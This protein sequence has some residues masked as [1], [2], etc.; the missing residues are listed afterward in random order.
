MDIW[1]SNIPVAEF[2]K[3]INGLL[4]VSGSTRK[5]PT[6]TSYRRVDRSKAKTRTDSVAHEKKS[7][8][9]VVSGV[10]GGGGGSWKR[11][12]IIY[13]HRIEVVQTVELYETV[14]VLLSYD[15]KYFFVER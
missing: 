1:W 6:S 13:T 11:R 7:T 3:C 5:T 10:L 12:Y 4:G 2:F 8:V 9:S 14:L 15:L